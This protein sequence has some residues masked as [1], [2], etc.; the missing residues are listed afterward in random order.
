MKL[1]EKTAALSKREKEAV[2]LLAHDCSQKEAAGKMGISP[3][4]LEQYLHRARRKLCLR[5][6]LAVVVCIVA[7]AWPDRENT[8]MT[9]NRS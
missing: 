2:F 5:S 8:V 7:P 9:G 4:T 3:R 6:T 1:S